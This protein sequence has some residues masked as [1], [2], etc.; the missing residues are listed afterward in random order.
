M[1]IQKHLSFVKLFLQHCLACR[2]GFEPPTLCLE[3]T[4]SNPT[5]LPADRHN[6]FYKNNI[7]FTIQWIFFTDVLSKTTQWT[8]TIQSPTGNRLPWNPR[9][10]GCVALLNT[11]LLLLK[12]Y[13][14]LFRILQVFDGAR[15]RTR[16]GTACAEGFSYHT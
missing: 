2:E 16:T 1:I 5:E 8:R 15:D 11:P 6:L 12:H 14:L 3:G 10:L 7:P 9:P 4:C 13:T